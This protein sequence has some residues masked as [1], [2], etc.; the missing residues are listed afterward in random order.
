MMV[1]ETTTKIEDIS[2]L[3]HMN[4]IYRGG[5]ASFFYAKKKKVNHYILAINLGKGIEMKK[6]RQEEYS[7]SLVE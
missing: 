1:A 3:N 6:P 2:I 4:K 5:N 7:I